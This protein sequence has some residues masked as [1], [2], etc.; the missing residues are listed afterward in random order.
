PQG[1]AA[2]GVTGEQH[3]VERQDQ[4]ADADTKMSR[5]GAIGE[6]V[7]FHRICGQ[8]ADEEESQVEKIPVHV[9]EHERER[10][11]AQVCFWRLTDG[12][13]RRVGPKRLIVG[14]AVVVTGESKAAR[15]PKYEQGR[16][17]GQRAGPPPGLRSEPGV[18]TVSEKQR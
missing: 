2:Q 5:A 15:R 12:A 17:E 14:T 7:R 10:A 18:V 11:L 4:A 6:P 13:R 9:L 3:R 8:D 1:M 16:R